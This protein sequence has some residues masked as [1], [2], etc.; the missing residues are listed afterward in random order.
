[1]KRNCLQTGESQTYGYDTKVEKKTCY[2]TVKAFRKINGKNVYEDM[3]EKGFR[4]RFQKNTVK[5]VTG[6]YKRGSIYGLKLNAKELSQVNF[7]N[8]YS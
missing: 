5:S 6:D 4:T 1:M 7:S 2:Y 8:N 3:D